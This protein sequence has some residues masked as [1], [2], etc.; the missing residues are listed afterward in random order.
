[1]INSLTA[2]SRSLAL[3]ACGVMAFSLSACEATNTGKTYSQK[4]LGNTASVETGTI[5]SSREVNVAGS[6]T[7][8][9]TVVGAGAGAVAGSALGHKTRTNILGA[10]GGAVLGGVIGHGVEDIATRGKATEFVVQ[11]AD[12]STFAVVQTNEDN[13]QPGER[14]LVVS[15]DKTRLT[16]DNGNYNPP[17]QRAA[18]GGGYGGGSGNPYPPSS[19]GAVTTAPP[20]GGAAGR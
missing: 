11:R 13:L 18:S 6:N 9:G 12:G 2:R 1:M 8:V 10:I 20:S 19:G 5:V 17:P 3:A 16:R 7:G 4:Q 15:G 14:V